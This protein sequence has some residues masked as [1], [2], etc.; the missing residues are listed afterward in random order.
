M[1]A[2]G[3]ALM[4]MR[5]A[6]DPR[7]SL[8]VAL[9][10]IARPEVD[11]SPAALVERLERLERGAIPT[12][13]EGDSPRPERGESPPERAPV[14]A[15]P[16]KALGAIKKQAAPKQVAPKQAATATATA[17][18]PTRDELTTAWADAVLPKLARKVSVWF[19]GRF[20]AVEDGRAVFA[21]EDQNFK[22]RAEK[23]QGD[24]E[25]ALAAHFGTA[26]PLQLTVDDGGATPPA[27]AVVEEHDEVDFDAPAVD[28]PSSPE[29]H[30]KKLFPGAE[31]V[32][33]E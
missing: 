4:Q 27:T 2:L 22:N 26:V 32:T 14:P 16:K 18:L 33:D 3:D 15:G 29:E 5:E 31:E 23:Y 30:L 24:V 9:V 8:E 12:R 1:E 13:S 17:D 11:V 6:L 20:V 10:R 28:A 21:L 7:V 19:K 25:A